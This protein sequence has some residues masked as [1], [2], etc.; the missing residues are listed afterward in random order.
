MHSFIPPLCHR[1]GPGERTTLFNGHPITGAFSRAVSKVHVYEIHTRVVDVERAYGIF[2]I[3]RTALRYR[4]LLL[5]RGWTCDI[6]SN[7]RGALAASVP[8]ECVV[9]QCGGTSICIPLGNANSTGRDCIVGAPDKPELPHRDVKPKT[10]TYGTILTFNICTSASS[11]AFSRPWSSRAWV[12]H[13]L[14]RIW[15]HLS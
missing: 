12:T 7:R 15:Y 9:P 10:R 8:C 6:L 5:N 4:R 13:P 14:K 11:L 3:K 2:Q 1:Y